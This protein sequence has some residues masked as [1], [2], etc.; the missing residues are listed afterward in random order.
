[1]PSQPTGARNTDPTRTLDSRIVE[2]LGRIPGRI[3]FGGLRRSLDAHPESLSRALRR[4]EREGIL[5]RTDAGYRL[6]QGP[7]ARAASPGK[8]GRVLAELR[9]PPGFDHHSVAARL[10]GRWFGSL[11]WVGAS[12]KD[13]EDRLVWSRRDGSGTLTLAVRSDTMRIFGEDSTEGI[14]ASEVEEGAYEL[15]F[16]ALE[17]LR[18][19]TDPRTSQATFLGSGEYGPSPFGAQG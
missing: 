15:L 6:L 18:L 14:D 17:Q 13:G 5:D 9:L 7:A 19:S 8:D 12:Q 2:A 16:H 10:N 3:S 4:L 1:M 11:R